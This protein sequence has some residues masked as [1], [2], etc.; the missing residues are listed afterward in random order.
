MVMQ[1]FMHSEEGKINASFGL[2]I[3]GK[4]LILC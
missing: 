2:N 1:D 4:I 3:V